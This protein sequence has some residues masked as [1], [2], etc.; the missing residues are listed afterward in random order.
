MERGDSRKILNA[1]YVSCCAGLNFLVVLGLGLILYNAFYMQVIQY[2]TWVERARAQTVSSHK[3]HTYR[4]SIYDRNGRLMAIS[5]PQRSL[6]ADGDKI[7]NPR[8]AAE[9]LSR[10]LGESGPHIERK[11]TRAKHFVWLKRHLADHQAVSIEEMKLRGVSLT[12][13]YKRFYP[14]RRVAGQI[15]GFVDAD[16]SGLEGIEKA[17]DEVLRERTSSVEQF[18]DGT[19]KA[20]WLQSAPPPEPHESRGVRLTLDA[21]IQNLAEDELEKAVSQY[22]ASSGEA[23]VLDAK[24]S[25]V[26]AMANWPFFDPNIPDKKNPDSWRNRIITDS[27]EPGSTFKVFLMS[28]AIQEGIFKVKDRVY[29]ENGRCHLAGHTINDTHP[30]GWLSMQEVIKYSSNIGASK[31][32]LQMGNERYSRYIKAFGFG[33]PTGISLPGEVKGLLRSYKKWRPIDLATT[34]FGQSIGVTSLQLT[35]AVACIAN[36][37]EYAP[38]LLVKD[39]LNAAGQPVNR[40]RSRPIR[41]VIQQKT[42]L[43][44]RDMMRSVTEEGGTGVKAVPDGY[45]A[46]GKT[47]TAQ[48]LDRQTR[49]YGNKYTSVFTGFIPAEDPRLVITVVVHEPHGSNYGGVVAAP[50][51]R[52]IAAKALPYMGVLPSPSV[53]PAQGARM[54]KASSKEAPKQAHVAESVKKETKAHAPGA[55]VETGKSGKPASAPVAKASS[56]ETPKSA[57]VTES[58]RK[59][60]KANAPGARVEAGKPG[61]PSGEPV[62][63]AS[64]GERSKASRVAESVKKEKKVTVLGASV[65]TGKSGKPNVAHAKPKGSQE[66][67]KSAQTPSD[68]YSLKVETQK[69]IGVD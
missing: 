8:K 39:L 13:E 36:G 2:P 4:G 55:R 60:K 45:T 63:R 25:E 14:Y 34:G 48:V 38:P 18:R 69:G 1:R 28:S 51:F 19:K 23:V 21:F 66:K 15:V 31:V 61:K 54:V 42:A 30:Y 57:H 20:I 59:E 47:G 64:S 56:K 65:E 33:S 7:E 40:F 35:M 50:V 27:F 16:G 37:G 17:F 3:E 10:V 44:I 29:C 26:L 9:Q 46:A 22:H 32:A 24:T 5:V 41:R 6:S 43:Q 58:A 67:A 68:K 62:A 53:C 12:D 49:R 52:N 11:L